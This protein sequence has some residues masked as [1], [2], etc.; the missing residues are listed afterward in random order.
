[1][2]EAVNKFGVFML[3]KISVRWNGKWHC[4][5]NQDCHSKA[6]REAATAGDGVMSCDVWWCWSVNIIKSSNVY[7]TKCFH[8]WVWVGCTLPGRAGWCHSL[9]SQRCRSTGAWP[10]ERPPSSVPVSLPFH[11]IYT[12][13]CQNQRPKPAH[14]TQ[15]IFQ[16]QQYQGALLSPFT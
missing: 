15:F 4:D 11:A 10:A 1:M 5:N 12:S 9:C 2:G 7:Y 16:T 6:R 13:H 8:T 3:F 14:K